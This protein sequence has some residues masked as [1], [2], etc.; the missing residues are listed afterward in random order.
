MI[1]LEAMSPPGQGEQWCSGSTGSGNQHVIYM[2]DLDA[3]VA[4]TSWLIVL[5]IDIL[6]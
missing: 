2:A 4:L 1:I 6:C 3:L 5:V